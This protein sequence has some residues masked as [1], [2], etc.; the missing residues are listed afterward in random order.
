MLG[1]RLTSAATRHTFMTR[2]LHVSIGSSID[3]DDVRETLAAL[4]RGDGVE[5][6]EPELH[7]DSL[8]TFGRLFRA[9]NLELLRAII[10]HGPE[11]I[12]ALARAVDR[13]PP[14]VLENLNELE[15]HGLVE[16]EQ[17]GRAKRPVVPYDGIDVDIPLVELAENTTAEDVIAG[18]K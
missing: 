3:H 7:I 1:E 2:T 6:A 14:E 16:F 5:P 8:A 4:D 11:S 12:R 9:T 13:N 18:R 15:A 17:D 10:N